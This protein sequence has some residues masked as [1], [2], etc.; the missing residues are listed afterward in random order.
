[1]PG[2]CGELWHKSARTLVPRPLCAPNGIS[3]RSI[4]I[5]RPL[6]TLGG[7]GESSKGSKPWSIFAG[8]GWMYIDARILV[9]RPDERL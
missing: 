3:E 2:E 6:D 7:L 9:E 1:M 5:L 4:S 8:V